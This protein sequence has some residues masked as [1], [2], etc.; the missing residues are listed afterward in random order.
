MVHRVWTLR[1]VI[2]VVVFYAPPASSDTTFCQTPHSVP[3]SYHF[4]STTLTLADSIL[5][6]ASPC[7]IVT[8]DSNPAAR[9]PDGTVVAEFKGEV[10]VEAP[11]EHPELHIN[12]FLQ[13]Y[14]IETSATSS[15]LGEVWNYDVP[16]TPHTT[17]K[18]DIAVDHARGW[19]PGRSTLNQDA[20]EGGI[21]IDGTDGSNAKDGGDGDV[22][23]GHR[24]RLRRPALQFG[25]PSFSSNAAAAKATTVLK[26][27]FA[28]GLELG[29]GEAHVVTVRVVNTRT[30]TVVGTPAVQRLRILPLHPES[31]GAGVFASLV[32]DKAAR[33][34]EE[35]AELEETQAELATRY[36]GNGLHTAALNAFPVETFVHPALL[37]ALR[38]AF[39]IDLSGHGSGHGS[40]NGAAPSGGN[41]SADPPFAV[42][43]EGAADVW[44]LPIFTE[45]FTTLLRE[46]LAHAQGFQH[47]DGLNWTRPVQSV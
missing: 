6:S 1:L 9:R 47:G 20:A 19:P 22:A 18:T 16:P 27:P 4:R 35:A 34:A 8:T 14:A 13:L 17:A 40:K 42:K 45:A 3:H 15:K 33:R 11:N 30:G 28:G 39:T 29:V 24:N 10:T 43:V 26:F 23:V 21:H 44:M 12:R 46:E 5:K 31:A 38:A 7:T 41:G 25:Q 32:A 36:A 37:A 2:A